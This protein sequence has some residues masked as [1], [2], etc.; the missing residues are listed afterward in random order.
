MPCWQ[1]CATP[2]HGG[3]TFARWT[4]KRT[5]TSGL[6]VDL[7]SPKILK[8]FVGINTLSTQCPPVTHHPLHPV[9][10]DNNHVLLNHRHGSLSGPKPLSPPQ[11][12]VVDR[13]YWPSR[14]SCLPSAIRA[15]HC[16]NREHMIINFPLNTLVPRWLY[17][18]SPILFEATVNNS[19]NQPCVLVMGMVISVWQQGSQHQALCTV[20][21]FGWIDR[22]TA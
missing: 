20:N 17:H 18:T 22:S 15:V 6:S 3:L 10:V 13:T 4:A 8:N 19:N 7:G 5:S 1:C 9:S 12:T 11:S 21:N 2:L 16:A 14:G